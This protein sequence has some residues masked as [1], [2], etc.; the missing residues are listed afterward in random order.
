M[1]YYLS[2]PAPQAIG[3]VVNGAITFWARVEICDRSRKRLEKR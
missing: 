1:K 3:D 2:V